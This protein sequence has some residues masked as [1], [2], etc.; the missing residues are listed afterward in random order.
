MSRR[1]AL[2]VVLAMAVLGGSI[3]RGSARDNAEAAGGCVRA[4]LQ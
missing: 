3:S 2:T 4:S 1:A